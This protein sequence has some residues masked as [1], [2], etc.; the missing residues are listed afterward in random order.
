[1]LQIC[2]CFGQNNGLDFNSK[3][4]ICIDFHQS[5]QCNN[6]IALPAIFLNGKGLQWCNEVKHLGNTITCCG[7]FEKDVRLKKGNF[8]SCVNGIITE[9]GFAH[10]QTKTGTQLPIHR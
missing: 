9:F 8:I 4:S 6:D 3:K 7:T 5:K 2:E 1:M 10:P